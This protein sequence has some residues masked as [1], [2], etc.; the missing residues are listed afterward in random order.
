MVNLWR[1]PTGMI[2]LINFNESGKVVRTDKQ[3]KRKKENGQRD[4]GFSPTYS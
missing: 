2:V 1:I 3:T 4:H